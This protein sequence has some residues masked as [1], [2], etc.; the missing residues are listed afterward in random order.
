MTCSQA[1]ALV[2]SSGAVVLTTGNGLYS[3]FVASAAYCVDLNPALKPEFAPTRD[4]AQ[5]FVGYG[6]RG[7]P[8][9]GND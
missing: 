8:T 4:N 7:R 9:R 6:C 2:K 3:R 1:Q 5:C